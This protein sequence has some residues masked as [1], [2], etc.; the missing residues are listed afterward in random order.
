MSKGLKNFFLFTAVVS[1]FFTAGCQDIGKKKRR[2]SKKQ[3]HQCQNQNA[4]P[5]CSNC[6]VD[7][8]D[9]FTQS[10]RTGTYTKR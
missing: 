5:S 2:H 10:C 8:S 7:C 3:T 9:C 6:I 4:S 1:L